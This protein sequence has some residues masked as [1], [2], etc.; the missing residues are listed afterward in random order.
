MKVLTLS[1]DQ[2]IKRSHELLSLIQKDL[3]QI[4]MLIGIATGGIYVSQPM[5]KVLQEEKWRGE[6]AEI[7]LSRPSTQKKE[8]LGVTKILTKLP[9]SLLNILRI[10]EVKMLE[11]F[12]SKQY[13]RSI[14]GRAHFTEAQSKSIKQSKSLLLIDDAIDTGSTMLALKN[15]IETINPTITVYIAVLTMTHKRPYI[16]PDYTL[17]KNVLLRCPWAMDYKGEDKIG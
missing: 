17:Y 3:K 15:V 7:K 8:S 14:E 12:N 13:D 11:T 10:I 9:Y 2:L 5:Y 4:D 16:Q 1:R 6:Y